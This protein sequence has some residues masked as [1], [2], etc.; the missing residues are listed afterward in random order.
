MPAAATPRGQR[1]FE[2]AERLLQGSF[3][4]AD[5]EDKLVAT[6]A[7]RGQVGRHA[8][9]RGDGAELPLEL[10]EPVADAQRSL[11]VDLVYARLGSLAHEWGAAD[12]C[13]EDGQGSLPATA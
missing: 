4:L 10:L 12:L 11:A 8:Q 1:G 5:G 7:D 9:L 13:E 3:L 2:H 6:G